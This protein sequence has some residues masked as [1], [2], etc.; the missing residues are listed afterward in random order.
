MSI[1]HEFPDPVLTTTQA[2]EQPQLSYTLCPGNCQ[3]GDGGYS[4]VYKAVDANS[5]QVVALKKSRVPLRIKRPHLRYES[6][7]LQLLQGH[8]AIPKILGQNL[9]D[10]IT[11][12]GT[13]LSVMTVVRVLEQIL[14]ALKH[15]H[16]HGLVHRD[17]K[18]QNLLCSD[19]DA[20]RIMLIDFGLTKRTI[21]GLPRTRDPL[22]E[23]KPIVGTLPWASLNSH[24]GTDLAP[25][26]DLKSLAYTVLFLLRGNMPWRSENYNPKEPKLLRQ[27]RVYRSKSSFAGSQLAM[28]F[29]SDFAYLLDYSRHLDFHQLPDYDD[30]ASRFSRLADSLGGYTKSDPLDWTQVPVPSGIDQQVLHQGNLIDEEDGADYEPE[31][32]DSTD[33]ITD[34]YWGLDVDQ[35]DDRHGSRDVSLTL[36]AAQL[37]ELVNSEIPRITEVKTPRMAANKK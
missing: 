26:D 15:V 35:W 20:S 12:E 31:D 4:K 30:L 18:P 17:I 3:L 27:T 21:P 22:K 7:V 34:S 6:W 37:E 10:K 23:K 8:T 32:G 29:P 5:G 2:K 25:R 9:R 16:K 24:R 13:G 36:P 19:Y 14:S 1:R 33:Y 11:G 28:N